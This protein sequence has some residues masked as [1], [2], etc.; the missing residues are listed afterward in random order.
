MIKYVGAQHRHIVETQT[1]MSGARLIERKS[2]SESKRKRQRQKESEGAKKARS[3]QHERGEIGRI[4]F[5]ECVVCWYGERSTHRPRKSRDP[6]V[7][8]YSCIVVVVDD[9][10][11]AAV[12]AVHILM[13]I[14]SAKEKILIY[15]YS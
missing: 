13:R 6:Y 1:Q 11:T 7:W 3:K 2:N 15:F 4:I 8:L 10:V 9:V 14:K 5:I 12:V